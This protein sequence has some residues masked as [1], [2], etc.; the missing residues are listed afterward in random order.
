MSIERVLGFLFLCLG[1]AII[2]FALFSSFQVFT[3]K[4]APPQIFSALDQQGTAKPTSGL[5]GQLQN[6]LSQQLK[7]FIPSDTVPKILNL[8][9]WSIF[10]GLLMFGGGQI[11]GIGVKLLKK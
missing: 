5:E 10:L 3:A 4:I 8:S 1:V 7:G 2:G 9:V 11:S 6:A